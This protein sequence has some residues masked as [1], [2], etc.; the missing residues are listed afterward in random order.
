MLTMKQKKKKKSFKKV[1]FLM[2][3]KSFKQKIVF[4]FSKKD[5]FFKK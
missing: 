1:F 3:Y 2:S 4:Q 5:V